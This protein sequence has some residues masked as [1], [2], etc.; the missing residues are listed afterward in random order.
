VLKAVTFD[1]W[2]TLIL[3]TAEG[4]RQARAGRVQGIHA[5]LTQH[6]HAVEQT[7]VEQAYDTVGER[8]EGIWRAQRDIGSHGQVRI[9]LD[10][11]GLGESIA[12]DRRI[13]AALE[14]AYCLPILS[15]MPMANAG[16]AETLE[17]LSE[18][19]MR[20]GLV[21]NTGRTPG[22][23]LRIVLDRLGLARYLSVLTFSD[24]VGL[25]KPHP[26]IFLRTLAVLGATPEEA[27][28]VGDDLSTDV[29]GARGIRLRAVHLRHARGASPTSDVPDAIPALQELVALLFP[30][31]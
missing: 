25:R 14:Q 31:G 22:T 27:A 20:L 19:G 6:G 5:L 28:H 21:C 12:G 9:L 7:A 30:G 2:Q 11:L 23:M 4:L 16:A 13:M 26:E 17:A 15:A 3:D 10:L 18:R 29:A 1:L 24:E 8:L